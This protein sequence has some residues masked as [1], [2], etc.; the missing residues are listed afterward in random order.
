MGAG[1]V[2]VW[3]L[4]AATEVS[5]ETWPGFRGD[6]S[7]ITPAQNLPVHWTPE[8]GVA[9]RTAV[10]GY[11]QSSPV[12]WKDRVFVTS[13]DGPKQERGLLHAFGLADGQRLWTRELTATQ[14][15]KNMF[16]NS[17]AASTPVV[18]GDGVYVLFAGGQLA[19][20]THDGQI[21]WQ[22]CLVEDYGEFRNGRGL[23]SSLA[24]TEHAVIALVDHDGPSYAVGVSKQTGENLWKADRGTR[25]SSWSSPLVAPGPGHPLVILSSSGTIEALDGETGRWLWGL[26]GLMGNHVPSAGF[27]GNR[28]FVGACEAEHIPMNPREVSRSNCSLR[29]THTEGKTGVDVVW[30][31]RRAVS[32]YSTPLAYRGGVYFV[33]KV[34]MLY[35]LDEQT[36]EELYVERIGGHCWAS[37]IG[38]GDHVYLFLKK[39]EVVVLKA[40]PEF[41][42]VAV[43]RVW[44]EDEDIAEEPVSPFPANLLFSKDKPLDLDSMGEGLLRRIFA[45]GDPIL[46]GAAAVEGHLLLRTG[47]ALICIRS[48]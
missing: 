34:G 12:V 37:A 2:I 46:Y 48:D 6:G 42:V 40:G 10:E 23:S 43:N 32:Y 45:Y 1:W 17:R 15:L 39:G 14:S 7:G 11:G 13:I 33:N 26:S 24:Q 20:L 4:L 29:L 5:A 36:G 19:G 21:R 41:E 38:A 9:W 22:R 44:S 47:E 35:C 3:S 18:D 27:S 16:R 28:L 31:A 25:S 30:R 8:E